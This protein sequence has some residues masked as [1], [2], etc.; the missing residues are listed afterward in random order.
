MTERFRFDFI[1]ENG[2]KDFKCFGGYHCRNG[3]GLEGLGERPARTVSGWRIA[4]TCQAASLENIVAA[5][6]KR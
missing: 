4:V 5:P 3:E 2:E 1:G 6:P